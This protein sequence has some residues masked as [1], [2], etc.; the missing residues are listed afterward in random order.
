MLII[1]SG[2]DSDAL[3]SDDIQLG[4]RGAPVSTYIDI[5]PRSPG[6]EVSSGNQAIAPVVARTHQHKNMNACQR[7]VVMPDT[8][9]HS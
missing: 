1:R 3:L 7:A 4:V 8:P 2:S 5:H 6:V 9:S